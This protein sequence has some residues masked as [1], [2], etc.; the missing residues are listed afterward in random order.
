MF[1]RARISNPKIP[2]RNLDQRPRTT[3]RQLLDRTTAQAFPEPALAVLVQ[4]SIPTLVIPDSTL[5]QVPARTRTT[6]GPA[7]TTRQ[8]TRPR[9]RQ[10]GV[11][12]DIRERDIRERDIRERD[13]LE[14]DIQEWDIQDRD[15]QDRDIR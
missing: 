3:R 4:V 13:I 10:P 15:I 6:R 11:L 1:S 12:Q 9:A 14:R 5:Y 7:R 2:L 8:D